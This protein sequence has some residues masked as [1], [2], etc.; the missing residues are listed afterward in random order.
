MACDLGHEGD[1]DNAR[2]RRFRTP[3]RSSHELHTNAR[4]L[5]IDSARP[6]PDTRLKLRW[7]VQNSAGAVVADW[8]LVG[9]APEQ[10]EAA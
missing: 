4:P 3:A 6:L 10:R 2:V 5:S 8:V 9:H 1:I 7:R